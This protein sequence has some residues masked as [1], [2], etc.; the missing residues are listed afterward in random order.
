MIG[1][2]R[3][4]RRGNYQFWNGIHN[5]SVTAFAV[6]PPFTQGRLSYIKYEKEDTH[7]GVFFLIIYVI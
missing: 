5:P 1:F 4:T 7:W 3:V 6:P 2:W